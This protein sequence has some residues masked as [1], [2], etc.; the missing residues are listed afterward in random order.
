MEN[1]YYFV[2]MKPITEYE[3][4]RLYLR[5]FYEER[6]K[7]SVFSWREFAK[8]AGFSSSGYLKLVCDGKT[9]LSKI[10]AVRSLRRW[11]SRG[12]RRTISV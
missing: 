4:Y 2:D 12:S 6:K 5:D 1:L 10:G 9:R 11:G 3:D 8:L 7:T